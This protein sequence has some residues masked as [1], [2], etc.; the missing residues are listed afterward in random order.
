MMTA[1][2]TTGLVLVALFGR[3]LL[4]LAGVAVLALPCLAW[5]YT[6]RA[7]MASWHRHHG[8]PAHHHA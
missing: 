6:A 1:L 8:H 5:A 7:V 2:S 4:V 3:A